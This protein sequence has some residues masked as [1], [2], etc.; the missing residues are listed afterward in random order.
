[1]TAAQVEYVGFKAN[2]ADREYTL[3][4]KRQDVSLQF[5]IVIPSAAFLSGRAR[6]QDAPEIYRF[7]STA[8]TDA[9][10]SLRAPLIHKY[11]DDVAGRWPALLEGVDAS[12]LR[13]GLT[14][15]QALET[16]LLLM[17]GFERGFTQLMKDKPDHGASMLP[18][19]TEHVRVHMKRLRD[20]LYC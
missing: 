14:V 11:R 15:T 13:G 7:I 16:M 9:P 1:M 20:G 4:L 2:V 3:R 8:M 18:A 10:E 12:R 19:L 5:T 17:D 6:F